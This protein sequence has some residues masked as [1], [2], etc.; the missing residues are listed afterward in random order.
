MT[1]ENTN[2]PLT[3][4]PSQWM[5]YPRGPCQVGNFPVPQIIQCYFERSSVLSSCLPSIKP[6]RQ[7]DIR[8]C[9]CFKA[10]GTHLKIQ[11][12]NI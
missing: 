10:F 9:L 2:L 5:G 4:T 11:N 12:V 1:D 3:L 6:W 8:R 7:S